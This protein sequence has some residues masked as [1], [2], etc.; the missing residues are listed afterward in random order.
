MPRFR[1]KPVEVEATKWLQMGDHPQVAPFGE[2][3]AS[4][5]HCHTAYGAHGYIITHEGGH[6]VCP[7]DWVVG[8]G[9]R[10]EFWPVKPD[11]F[12]HKYE[13]VE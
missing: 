9:V 13:L 2:A 10:G 11:A 12:A 8:P 6:I 5:D 4:C 3:S 7:G 1:A